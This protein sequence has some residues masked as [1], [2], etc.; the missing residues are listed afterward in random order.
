MPDQ[1]RNRLDLTAQIVRKILWHRT[2]D[3]HLIEDIC[4]NVLV[5]CWKEE[6][7]LQTLCPNRFERFVIRVTLNQFI[8]TRRKRKMLDWPHGLDQSSS[9]ADPALEA[10]QS[11]QSLCVDSLLRGLPSHYQD[12]TRLRIVDGWTHERIASEKGLPVNTI[13]AQF[14]RAIKLLKGAVMRRFSKWQ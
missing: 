12:V 9:D 3:L 6:H 11:E 5:V 8:S 10:E 4:Q 14:R 7:R 1:S 13:K 2:K